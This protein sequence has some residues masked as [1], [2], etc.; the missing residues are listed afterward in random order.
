MNCNHILNL[1]CV[2]TAIQDLP[3]DMLLQIIQNISNEKDIEIAKLKQELENVKED[4]GEFQNRTGDFVNLFKCYDCK[5]WEVEDDNAL[6]I[7]I[8]NGDCEGF[9]CNDCI[10]NIDNNVDRQKEILNK[11]IKYKVIFK[12]HNDYGSMTQK[13]KIYDTYQEIPMC[14]KKSNMR[15]NKTFYT[16][17]DNFKNDEDET[18]YVNG[19]TDWNK[20]YLRL[21][22]ELRE[23]FEMNNVYCHSIIEKNSSYLYP[24]HYRTIPVKTLLNVDCCENKCVPRDMIG[25]SWNKCQ[26][27]NCYQ[28]A[29]K[30]IT[31]KY[32]KLGTK[33]IN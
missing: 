5:C 16:S 28:C 7:N 2:M 26:G 19:N 29:Y 31:E 25:R 13:K 17:W 6:F 22:V 10:E 33:L 23:L 12:N 9:I 21:K 8:D 20:N 30:S 4:F 27:F 11:Y 18:E 32:K 24:N 3:N 15:I 1:Y 14:Y